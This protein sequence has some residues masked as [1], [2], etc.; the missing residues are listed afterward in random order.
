MTLASTPIGLA[1]VV[2]GVT[3]GDRFTGRVVVV[4]QHG[5]V[6][7]VWATR[8]RASQRIS[9]RRSCR[10]SSAGARRARRRQCRR[11]DSSPTV[12][13]HRGPP[14][15]LQEV[16]ADP[17]PSTVGALGG[18][19]DPRHRLVE[20]HDRPG[21]ADDVAGRGHDRS[22]RRIRRA[23]CR[24]RVAVAREPVDGGHSRRVF[25][26]SVVT[27]GQCSGG[28]STPNATTGAEYQSHR[29]QDHPP[30]RA[31]PRRG[32]RRP[33]RRRHPSFDGRTGTDHGRAG[34]AS[35]THRHRQVRAE[36]EPHRCRTVARR[37]M[38]HGRGCTVGHQAGHYTD[39]ETGQPVEQNLR[40]GFVLWRQ[41]Q[42]EPRFL[43]IFL[44]LL[45]RYVYAG[46]AAHW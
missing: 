3:I 35:T 9:C 46:A 22:P 21:V 13:A 20:A 29:R 8:N 17:L 6:G 30:R 32:S 33:L 42:L 5:T 14:V 12:E 41:Q 4:A 40:H 7:S 18:T 38:R 23:T 27:S 16:L 2:L 1:G 28:A 34:S 19:R 45:A 31:G 44:H 11:T 36:H 43:K 26:A 37:P 39:T 25:S 15:T 10:R 24:R